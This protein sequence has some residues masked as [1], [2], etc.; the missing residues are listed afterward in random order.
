MK[1]YSAGE[2]YSLNVGGFGGFDYI[3]KELKNLYGNNGKIGYGGENLAKGWGRKL[4]EKEKKH[5][6]V[7]LKEKYAS[8]K[9]IPSFLNKIHKEET[10]KI[11]GMKNS[12]SQRG[13]KN[14]QYG[15]M[16]IT[17]GIVNKKIKKEQD[18][19]FGWKRGRR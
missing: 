8:G 18:I 3:N 7:T 13:E 17:D 5:L 11:I 16:W 9:I 15:T 12:L 4:S 1:T 19:P 14:S 2:V 6:S 10:K